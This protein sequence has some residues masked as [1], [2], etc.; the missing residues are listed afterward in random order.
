MNYFD[1]IK[2]FIV[3][4][5]PKAKYAGSLNN[6]VVF[7]RAET[8]SGALRAAKEM[9]DEFSSPRPEYEKGLRV[10]ELEV[11]KPFYF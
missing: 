9:I 1:K 10:V 6:I 7:I 3:I 11:A 4:R 5:R 2:T 8:K